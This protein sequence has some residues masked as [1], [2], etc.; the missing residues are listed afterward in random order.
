[1]LS[2]INDYRIEIRKG[3]VSV[4]K[5]LRNRQ[6]IIVFTLPALAVYTIFVFYP[7]CR[8]IYF[9]F[10][11]G[12]P[13]VNF[14]W[15]G[16]QNYIKLVQDSNFLGSFTV[17]IQ[18]FIVVAGGWVL[19]GLL[20]ALLFAYGMKRGVNVARTIIYLPVVIPTVGVAAMFSKIF[21]IEPYY[22]LLNSLLA[23]V[24]LENLVRAW[25]GL[26]STALWT[27]CIAD[28][29]RGLGYYAILFYAGLINIPR[30]LEEAARI[31]GANIFQMIWKIVLPILKP[32]TIMATVLAVNNAL[33]VYDMPTIL[34][35]G[36][37]G[38]S[39]QTL[40][41]LM[42]KEAFTKME[43]GYGSTIAVIILI[44]TLVFTQSI[45]VMDRKGRD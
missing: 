36:G 23:A 13:N 2:A 14:Q 20:A 29:W 6:A 35:R 12:T 10:F 27:I 7:M 32:V 25:T 26:S 4:D 22:G 16:F 9:T 18:Y 37:P 5:I 15:V 39:T 44:I 43:Y 45:A 19:F 30:E 34:T 8:S 24:G 17:T 33:R 28:M 1:M 3:V 40:S 11:K 41:L 21:E 38:R 31:D 42:Y